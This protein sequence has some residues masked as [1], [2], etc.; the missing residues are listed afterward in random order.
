MQPKRENR[1]HQYNPERRCAASGSGRAAPAAAARSTA[2]GHPPC[3]VLHAR[4]VRKSRAAHEAPGSAPIT[5]V[6]VRSLPPAGPRSAGTTGPSR[7]V[8]PGRGP[9]RRAERRAPDRAPA[10]GGCDDRLPVS[11]RY[12]ATVVSRECAPAPDASEARASR[13]VPCRLQSPTR[14]ASPSSSPL[15]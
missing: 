6:R 14:Q 4:I 7:A 12:R 10:H 3:A 9:R 1:P 5:R 2:I 13:R 8:P 15:R 11:P